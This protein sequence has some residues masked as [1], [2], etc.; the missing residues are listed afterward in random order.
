[1][2]R[3]RYRLGPLRQVLGAEQLSPDRS[4]QQ[5]LAGV[6]ARAQEAGQEAAGLK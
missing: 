4:R 6:R 3:A 5:I 1:V 2:L